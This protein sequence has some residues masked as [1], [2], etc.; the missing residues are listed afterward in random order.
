[1]K[2]SHKHRSPSLVA[3]LIPI[4][5][6]IAGLVTI[7]L[8]Y[9]AGAVQDMSHY[10]LLS[11]AAIAAAISMVLYRRPGGRESHA[12]RVVEECGTSIAYNTHIAHDSYCSGYLDAVGSC[13]HSYMLWP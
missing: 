10:I 13:S 2:N 4:F 7:I 5:I 9:G 12:H 1:M 11:A 6:L 3:S 8:T